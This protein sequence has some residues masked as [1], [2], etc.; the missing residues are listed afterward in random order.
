MS[1]AGLQKW[2]SQKDLHILSDP[3]LSDFQFVQVEAL[4]DAIHRAAVAGLTHM[5]KRG[6]LH[7]TAGAEAI[8]EPL[9]SDVELPQDVAELGRMAPVWFVGASAHARWRKVIQQAVEKGELVLLDYGSKLPAA[10]RQVSAEAEVPAEAWEAVAR[11]Y[12]TEHWRVRPKGTNPS[13]GDI[14]EVV[15]K[16]FELEGRH[17]PRGPRSA[18]T[19]ARMALTSWRKPRD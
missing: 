8:N 15:R 19:I 16:R 5:S 10:R 18:A 9:L 13:K 11:R 1:V 17:G 7:D 6:F 3:D 12:A 2:A 14:A 4:L